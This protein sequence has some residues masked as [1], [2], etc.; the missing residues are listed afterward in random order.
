MEIL[1]S[2]IG[3]LYMELDSVSEAV[4]QSVSQSASQLVT[5]GFCKNQSILRT[6]IE[7]NRRKEQSPVPVSQ[8]AQY[9]GS[10]KNN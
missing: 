8:K 7:Q 4:S 3:L 5:Q 6:Q 10:R 1:A 9:L 2:Q